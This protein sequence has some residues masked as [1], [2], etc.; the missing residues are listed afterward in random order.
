MKRMGHWSLL[1]SVACF[2][3]AGSEAI[4]VSCRVLREAVNPGV[5]QE[6][7]SGFVGFLW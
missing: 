6:G 3:V 5:S 7:A 1:T 2:Q 4:S